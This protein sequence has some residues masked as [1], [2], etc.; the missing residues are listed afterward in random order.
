MQKVLKGF[1]SL[2]L[3]VALCLGITTFERSTSAE[4]SVVDAAVGDYYSS[5]TA[6]GGTELLGQLHDLITSTHTYYTSYAGECRDPNTVKLTDPGST[7]AYVS[8]FY[9]QA[10]IAASWGAGKTGTW[11]REHV[12]CQSLSNGLWG[13]KGGGADLHHIRPVETSL[14][15]SRGNN[16][17]GEIENRDEYK[18]YYKDSSSKNVAHGGYISGGVYEPLN[19]VKGD[20][21]RIVLYVYTHYNNYSNSIFEGHATENGNASSSFFGTLNFTN[22]MNAST[23]GEALGILLQWNKEDP[24]SAIERTRN[25]AVAKIQGNRNPFIDNEDYAELIWG[26][27]VVIPDPSVT[28]EGISLNKT[29]VTLKEG[30]S[31]K[32]V[33]SPYPINAKFSVTWASSDTSIANVNSNGAITA[34]AI[35]TTTITATATSNPAITASAT[36]TVVKSNYSVATISIESFQMSNGY[37]FKP[38]SAGGLSGSAFIY[39]GTAGYPITGY[40]QFNKTQDSYYLASSTPAAGGIRSVT[41]K[42]SAGKAA[43]NWKLLTSSTPYGEIKGKPTNGTDQGTESVDESGVTWTVEGNDTYF[44]LV[45]E[46]TGASYLDCIIV[47]YGEPQEED[48]GGET[49]P[50]VDPIPNPNVS[51]FHTAV[52]AISS[53]GTLA[54]RRSS[55]MTAITA[56]QALTESDKALAAADIA[57]LHAAIDAYNQAIGAYNQEAEQVNRGALSGSNG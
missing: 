46:D 48:G 3:A 15:S 55:I 8:E 33:A 12:W 25:E 34:R 28:L 39:G 56:Y 21:A 17:Y 30:K 43:K 10:D 54:Q 53:S 35:G 19:Q 47:E 6:E 14:N 41:V 1:L 29:S 20:V 4:L 44:A 40:L 52:I 5:I 38:W 27:S 36:V 45:Y 7:S 49:P 57:I 50:V 11:N 13:E 9:S 32:L 37:S 51:A 18:A 22:I 31:E 26:D 16:R 2:G 24:V 23:E 42:T